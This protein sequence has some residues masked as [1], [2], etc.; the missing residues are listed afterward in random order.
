[1]KLGSGQFDAVSGELTLEG[2]STRLRPRT[3]ALLSYLITHAGRVVGKDELL[4]AIWPKVVVT[5]DSIVQCVKEIRRAL[6]QG[7]QHWIRTVPREGYAFVAPAEIPPEAPAKS[8][9]RWSGRRLAVASAAVV[10]MA[11][12]IG[13]MLVRGS[14]RVPDRYALS[15][16]VLPVA[17]LTGDPA[18]ENEAD[19]ITEQLARS[20]SRLPGAFVIAPSTAFTFKRQTV[21]VRRVG[22]DLGVRYVLEGALRRQ[23]DSRLQLTVAMSDSTNAMQLWSESFET[24]EKDPSELRTDVVTRVAGSLG[25]RLVRLEALR[26]RRDHG[27]QDAA[28]LLSRARAALRWAGQGEQGVTEARQLLE[29]VVR[30]D[31]GLADAWAL[32]A[33]ACLDEIRFRP[34]SEEDLL[35]ASQAVDRA[36]SLAPDNADAL[37]AK[38]RLQYNRG[39]M[40]QALSSF[41]RAIELNPSDPQWHGHSAAT[42]IMLGRPDEALA[43]TERATHLS[44]RDP[45]LSLW[46]MFEGV[47]L[48]HLGRHEAAVEALAKAVAGN[49]KS[50]FARL[51]LASALGNTGRTDEAGI[52]VKELLRLRPGFT[53][54]HFRSREPSSESRFLA[55]RQQVYQGLRR[56]GLAD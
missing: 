24:S 25:L 52:Q 5:E 19:E 14:D 1:M 6:G 29:E 18:L 16:V 53:L 56:A 41:Q 21:D 50:A 34:G 26:S 23:Q 35:R 30:R 15:L 17:N 47:A 37:G 51:F 38:A 55:Q 33:W 10:L 42:L 11:S 20:L 12:A 39:Q 27:Q 32:L 44:P 48:L 43:A 36:I 9:A 4:Q 45:Q 22:S 54:S 2:R 49:P 28:A 31:E 40:P 13:F 8:A 46:Q 3:A 7:R